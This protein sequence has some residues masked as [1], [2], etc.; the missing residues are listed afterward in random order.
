[1]EVDESVEV[2]LEISVDDLCVDSV[3][4]NFVADTAGI[5]GSPKLEAIMSTM[6]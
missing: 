6:T 4:E 5:E 1:M 2:E 3:V